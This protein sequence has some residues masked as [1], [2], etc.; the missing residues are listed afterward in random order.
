[1]ISILR[2][3][4]CKMLFPSGIALKNL[5]A[6]QAA[7][8][9]RSPGEGSGSP[10]QRCCLVSDKNEPLFYQL[11]QGQSLGRALLEPAMQSSVRAVLDYKSGGVLGKTTPT[12][13]ILW[14]PSTV[15]SRT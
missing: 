8:L 11:Q 3:S 7:G 2:D 10:L 14:D 4:L 15:P 13:Q 5:P 12:T 6:V 9:G 1:M